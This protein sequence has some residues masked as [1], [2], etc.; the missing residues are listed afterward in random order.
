MTQ[1]LKEHLLSLFVGNEV[2]TLGVF[3]SP[4][5]SLSLFP[6][7]KSIGLDLPLR[8]EWGLEVQG[9]AANL[10]GFE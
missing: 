7:V 4:S 10:K 8:G 1:G 9:S 6:S 3:F 2:M 5:L